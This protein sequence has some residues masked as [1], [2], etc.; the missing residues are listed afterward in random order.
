MNLD[1][2]RAYLEEHVPDP[3]VRKKLLSYLAFVIIESNK[4]K[5]DNWCLNCTKGL[6][7]LTVGWPYLFHFGPWGDHDE[8]AILVIGGNRAAFP[9][10]TLMTFKKYVS[11][12]PWKSISPKEENIV[13]EIPAIKL[14]VFIEHIDVFKQA[15]RELHPRADHGPFSSADSHAP[16]RSRL[17]PGSSQ[18]TGRNRKRDQPPSF[19]SVVRTHEEQ[20]D[21]SEH[22]RSESESSRHVPR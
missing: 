11:D 8:K 9:K 14:P 22:L 5:P 17:S 4:I 3:K 18:V 15:I 19:R 20:C 1:K 16:L 7:K 10:E 2:M 12:W 6:L 13:F 21:H